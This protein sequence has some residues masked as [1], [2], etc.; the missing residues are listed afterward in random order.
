[1]KIYGGELIASGSSTIIPITGLATTGSNTFSGTQT[2]TGSFLVSGSILQNGGGLAVQ[3]GTI[4][5]SPTRAFTP[6]GSISTSGTAVT[7]VGNHFDTGVVGAKLTISGESRIITVRTSATQV[8][9]DS[10]YSQNYSGVIAGSWGAYYKTFEV[11][12]DGY[13]YFYLGNQ[14][15]GATPGSTFIYNSGG[16]P[17]TQYGW[18]VP[19]SILLN[20]SGLSYGKDNV[21]KWS[22]TTSYDEFGNTTNDIGVRRNAAGL[23]EIYNGT[24]RD[25]A[26]A[27]RR[28][29]LVR[30]ITGSNAAFSS[31]L[32][33]NNQSITMGTNQ[34]IAVSVVFG[35]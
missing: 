10:T 6:T 34:M 25:G 17:S 21:I 19:S 8:T 31:S 1:M 23:L 4:L 33:I 3:D 15:G 5:Y 14:S 26:I 9:V 7:V 32:S 24:T 20:G 29:L 22:N 16:F 18:S 28:D 12:T 27:N 2:V 13:P 35:G 11:K 30:D